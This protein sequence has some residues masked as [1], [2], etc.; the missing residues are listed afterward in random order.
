[1][2]GIPPKNR[3][4]DFGVSALNALTPDI[5]E[6]IIKLSK[7]KANPK[8]R[9]RVQ[10]KGDNVVDIRVRD[11]ECWVINEDNKWVDDLILSEARGLNDEYFEFDLSGLVE[12]PQL[13]RY[14]EGGKYDWHIDIGRGD[15][16]TRKLSLTWTLNGDFDGGDFCFFQYG[17]VSVPFRMGQGCI[18]PS[19]MPHRVSEVT[20]G[21][22]W[23]LVAWISGTPFR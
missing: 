18:F 3:D 2:R 8:V 7:D 19:F 21:E 6:R 4:R 20:F 9:G 23:A 22:R 12:R 17:E 5:C 11:V 15:S 1:M 16:S 14:P 10:S 13:L